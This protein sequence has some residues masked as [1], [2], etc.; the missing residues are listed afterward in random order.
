LKQWETA[1]PAKKEL[2]MAAEDAEAVKEPEK[3]EEAP[4]K[5]DGAQ[6]NGP[7]ATG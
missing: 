5:L 2:R 6:R 4:E 1:N 3:L 7:R